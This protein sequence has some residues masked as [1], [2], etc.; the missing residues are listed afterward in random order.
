M[1]LLTK[2]NDL[3]QSTGFQTLVMMESGSDNDQN[4]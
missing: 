3:A 4:A 2:L 1:H